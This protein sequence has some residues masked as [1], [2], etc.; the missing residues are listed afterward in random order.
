MYTFD[1]ASCG[2]MCVSNFI[3]TGTGVQEVLRFCLKNLR[4]CSVG[5]TDEKDL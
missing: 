1:I 5:I 4:G 2:L 3:K